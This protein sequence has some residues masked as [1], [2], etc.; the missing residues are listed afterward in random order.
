M[1]PACE[2]DTSLPHKKHRKGPHYMSRRDPTYSHHSAFTTYTFNILVIFYSKM[3]SDNLHQLSD[4]NGLDVRGMKGYI[5]SVQIPLKL[6][7]K[8]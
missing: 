7:V 6:A 1:F 5:G 4:E 2:A 3:K 8:F